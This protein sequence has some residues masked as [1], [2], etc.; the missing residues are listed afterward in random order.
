ME[1][2]FK[3]ALPTTII[4]FILSLNLFLGLSRLGQYSAVD[5]PYWTYDR[6][7]DFW[8][9][10]ANQK[11][12]KTDINDKPGITVAILSG[13][14]LL[15]SDPLAYKSLRD[16]PKTEAQLQI[17]DAIN[18]NLRLPIFLF[19]IFSLPFF[20]L[21]L[22]KLFNQSTAILGFIFIG[23]SPIILGIS[24]IINP[25]SLLWI[26]AT[27]SVLA[28]LIF[29]KNTEKKYLY[30]SGMLLGMALLTK[31]VANILYVFFLILPF[32]EYIFMEEKPPLK[33]YLQKFIKDYAI[34]ILVS[35]LTFFIFY[36]ATWKDLDILWKG[37]FLSDAFKKVWPLFAAVLVL[38]FADTAAF[39]QKI[40]GFI[41]NILSRYRHWLIQF[42]AI[43]FIIL[44]VF[45]FL[46]VYSSMKPF[47]FESVI[48]SPKGIGIGSN[49]FEIFL[50]SITA[51]LYVLIF[52]LS[53][54]ALISFCVA[55]LFNL[56]K[57][58]SYTIEARV[59]LYFSLFIL[60][61]YL[62]STVNDVIATVR[63]QII[64]YPFAFI[65]GAIG[66]NRLINLPQI[67]KIIPNAG[68]YFLIIFFSIISLLTV[69]PFYFTYASNFLP[70]QYI[71]NLKDMGD[72]SYEA[73]QF[74][75]QLPNAH[76]LNIW[77]DKGAVCA[78]FVGNC[79]TNFKER[80]FE[81][82][83]FEYFVL[84]M[85]RQSR[86]LKLSLGVNDHY[87]FKKAYATNETIF[88]LVLDNRPN[89]FIKI[90][91]TA[92]LKK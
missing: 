24:L 90:V 89:N 62:A 26:F 58:T 15:K 55:L 41:L 70:Q 11:W 5:E 77:S 30:F 14:G 54:I 91:D 18:F 48:S 84:S 63:Y 64:I 65:I 7:P 81:N 12:S 34:L 21:F 82:A 25:D 78:V 23:L 32:L 88:N 10:I 44:I 9:A 37:T 52:G 92:I 68:F 73:A 50:R 83:N 1:I 79:T 57:K 8:N 49:I 59:T 28:Y 42:F 47:D 60:F 4:V 53:P 27:L 31:Y 38:I 72:G 33:N 86:T 74:L 35:M 20:Y 66:L 61:Y 13:I 56:K 17:I 29:Q 6:T 75:N 39:K 36:P 85:G 87:D 46:D 51:N 16:D 69:K 2:F 80:D 71:L 19:Y 40:F 45:V 3:K 76:E 67:K 43:L 22:R